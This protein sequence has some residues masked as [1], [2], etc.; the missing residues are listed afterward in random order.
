MKKLATSK[1]DIKTAFS[2]IPYIATDHLHVGAAAFGHPVQQGLW[3]RV[4]FP[5][6]T[7]LV[8]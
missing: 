4:H 7:R 1:T 3:F 5:T 6:H 2:N 8:L